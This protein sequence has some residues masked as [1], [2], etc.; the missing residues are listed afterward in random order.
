VSPDVDRT[1]LAPADRRENCICGGVILVLAGED[2]GA[3]VAMHNRSAL[4]LFWRWRTGRIT[5]HRW[6]GTP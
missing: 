4:H 1:S 3:V 6:L 2:I 5:L